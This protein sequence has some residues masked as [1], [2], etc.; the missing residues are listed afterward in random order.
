MDDDGI[1]DVLKLLTNLTKDENVFVVSHKMKG[2]NWQDSF[3]RVLSFKKSRNF[4][5]LVA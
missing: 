4:T 1:A 3:G 5:K 2:N